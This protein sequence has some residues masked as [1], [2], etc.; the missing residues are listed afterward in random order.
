MIEH[1]HILGTPSPRG[2]YTPAVR[3]GNFL[4]LSGQVAI[5]AATNET[6]PGGTAEQTRAALTNMQRLLEGCG[7]RLEDVV[8]CSVFLLDAADFQQ[9]NSVYEEFF[10]Q[11]KPART[12]VTAALMDARLRVEIECIAYSGEAPSR[13]P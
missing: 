8:K 12:T 11:A 7:A 1:L 10:P 3:A 2:P 13:K 6:V 5:D 9:M 4:F